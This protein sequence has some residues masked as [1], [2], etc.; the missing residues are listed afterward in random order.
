MVG[1]LDSGG[2]RTDQDAAE[3]EAENQR[4][5]EAPGQQTAGDSGDKDVGQIAKENWI[6]FHVSAASLAAVCGQIITQEHDGWR[7]F[8][9]AFKSRLRT[10]RQHARVALVCMR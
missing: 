1:N 10:G 4:E 2:K 7:K 9:T 5:L 8:S 6:G 3:D